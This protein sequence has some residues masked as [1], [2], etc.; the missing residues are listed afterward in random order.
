MDCNKCL[1]EKKCVIMD[2]AEERTGSDLECL[3]FRRS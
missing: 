3:R 2:P 1:E